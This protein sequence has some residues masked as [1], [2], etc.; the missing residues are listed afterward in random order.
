M[1]SHLCFVTPAVPKMGENGKAGTL[2][3][4]PASALTAR[5]RRLITAYQRSHKREQLRQ[6]AL[7]KPDGRRRRRH[8]DDILSMVTEGGAY[9]QD[10]AATAFLADNGSFMKSSPFLPESAALLADGAAYFKERRQR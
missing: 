2:Y 1:Q 5:L 7:T 8:R 3:W 10:V 9:G 6:E 4:P